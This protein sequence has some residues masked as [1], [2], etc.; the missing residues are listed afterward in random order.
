MLGIWRFRGFGFRRGG[1]GGGVGFGD[2]GVW[3]LLVEGSVKVRAWSVWGVR[4]FR[5]P[6]RV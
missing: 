6:E 3:G 4:V 2:L 1:G 5:V